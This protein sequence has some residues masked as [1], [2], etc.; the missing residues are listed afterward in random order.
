MTR[1]AE[2]AEKQWGLVTRRQLAL[3]GV[4]QTTVERLTAPQSTLERV[5]HGVYHLE[6]APTPDH[7]ELPAAWLQLAPE[8]QAWKRKAAEGVVSHRSAAALYGLGHL[9]A[10]QHEFTVQH[11]KQTKRSDVRLH[12]RRLDDREWIQLRGMPVTRPARMAS[13]LLYDHEDPAAVAQI[14]ADAIRPVFDYPGTFAQSLSPHSGR[15][16]LRRNDGLALLQWLLDLVGDK[17]TPQWMRA[18]ARIDDASERRPG[19]R[20]LAAAAW[21]AGMTERRSSYA[22]PV[23]FRRALTG[24]LKTIELEA[25]LLLVA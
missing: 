8:V 10:D 16:G 14:V 11:R 9:P 3:A 17:E 18:S 23:A 12:R 20:R 24:K 19:T 15:F 2:I 4:P 7:L 22:S 1:I 13:D 25:T 6:G 5:A 21:V